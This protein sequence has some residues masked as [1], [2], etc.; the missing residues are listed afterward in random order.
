MVVPTLWGPAWFRDPGIQLGRHGL[1]VAPGSESVR[2][3][4]R[5]SETHLEPQP[6]A[7]QVRRTPHAAEA[8]RVTRLRA[9][10]WPI[11]IA[12]VGMSEVFEPHHQPGNVAAGE[13]LL[14]Q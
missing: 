3:R 14:E 13:E 8:G 7:E 2:A 6:D 11:E 12:R 9:G 1:R 10:R 5:R 4:A